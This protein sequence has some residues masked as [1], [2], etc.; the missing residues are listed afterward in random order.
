MLEPRSGESY[1]D[2]HQ[3]ASVDGANWEQEHREDIVGFI[4]NIPSHVRIDSGVGM[5]TPTPP[6]AYIRCV[7]TAMSANRGNTAFL[8]NA[9]DFLNQRLLPEVTGNIGEYSHQADL[10]GPFKSTCYSAEA[11]FLTALKQARQIGTDTTDVES[12]RAHGRISVYSDESGQPVLL[13]KQR[14]HST[15]LTLTNISLLG[16]R[17]FILPAGSIVSVQAGRATEQASKDEAGTRYGS[18]VFNKKMGIF[19][20]RF[21]PW[22]FSD[23]HKRALFASTNPAIKQSEQE[24]LA[25]ITLDD[26]KE[27]AHNIAVLTSQ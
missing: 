13:R 17:G 24:T 21:S 19:P 5:D 22:V 18:Y 14:E 9:A 6:L 26:F 4:N 25:N 8:R 1:S 2:Y 16:K 27:A 15:A 20:L 12:W 3:R 10:R 23:P 11:Q 7:F